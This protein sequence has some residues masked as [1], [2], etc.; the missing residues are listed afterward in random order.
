MPSR[1]RHVIAVV[2]LVPVLA[3]LALWAFAWP[4]SRIAP[5]DLP[6][7]VAGPP[8]A[9][10]QVE[11]RLERHEGAFEI[12]RYADE[13]AARGAIEDRSVYGAVVVTPQGPELLT[14][15]AAGPVVAQFL[16]QAMAQQ[17]SAQGTEVKTVDV[18]STPAGDPRGAVLNAAALPLALAGIAA[19]A[20]VTLLGLRGSR[21]VIAL[22][23]ASALVGVIAAGIAHSWLGALSGAWWTEASVLGLSTLAVGGA[24]AGLA[25]LIGTA[26]VGVGAAMVM[27]IG[28]PFSGATSAPQMLPEPAGA[29]G[30]WLPPG[31]GTTLLRSV[32]YFDGAAATGP[33]LT[34]AWWAALGLGAVLLGSSLRARKAGSAPAAERQE[35]SAVG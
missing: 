1:N 29:I 7:G 24:V 2:V 9:A 12:H 17:A 21:A 35:L 10:A 16:Q 11:Q 5:R 34:L 20:V 27:L 31:A 8:A 32:S 22:L 14:A 25:A 6:L 23:G 28:N 3:A 4:A 15:S 30:Q 33:A 19:G 13:A 18:V 26:G